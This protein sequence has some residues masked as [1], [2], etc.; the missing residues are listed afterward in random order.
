VNF[1]HVRV[2]RNDQINTESANSIL[3]HLLVRRLIYLYIVCGGDGDEAVQIIDHLRQHHG[4]HSLAIVRA[5]EIEML[6]TF[7]GT[8]QRD[9]NHILEGDPTY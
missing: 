6:S 5:L 2:Y 9:D 3:Q 4:S 8:C 7:S 1:P